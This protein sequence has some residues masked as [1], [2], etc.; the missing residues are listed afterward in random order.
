LAKTATRSGKSK[1]VS[2]ADKKERE[3]K[4]RT[5]RQLSETEVYT[6]LIE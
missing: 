4:K 1:V 2:G 3:T 5:G 6:Q